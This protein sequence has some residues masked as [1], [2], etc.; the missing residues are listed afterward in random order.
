MRI[1]VRKSDDP[2]LV[3]FLNH[4]IKNMVEIG[5]QMRTGAVQSSC[6]VE[7]QYFDRKY[8]VTKVNDSQLQR[9]LHE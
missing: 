3:A 2:D 7:R 6:Y 9:Q 1:S 4:Y 5:H 8:P